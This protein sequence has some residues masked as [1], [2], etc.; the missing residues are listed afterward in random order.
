MTFAGM[1][2]PTCIQSRGSAFG[3]NAASTVADRS[4]T[5][6]SREW[7]FSSTRAGRVPSTRSSPTETSRMIRVV[8]DSI[9]AV[10]RS[11]GFRPWKKVGVSSTEISPNSARCMVK[12]WRTSGKR[13]WLIASRFDRGRSLGRGS[14]N[15]EDLRPNHRD[16][17]GVKFGAPAILDRGI[18]PQ[19][20][21]PELLGKAKGGRSPRRNPTTDSEKFSSGARSSRVSAMSSLWTIRCGL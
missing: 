21:G 1:D 8:P 19:D 5:R 7:P 11:P 17:D 14:T 20:R 13:V 9:S 15:V 2:A 3:R 6:T 18:T 10:V 4:R 12:S 16:V